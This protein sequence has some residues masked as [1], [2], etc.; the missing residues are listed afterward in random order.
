MPHERPAYHAYCSPPSATAPPSEGESFLSGGDPVVVR[1]R[2][3]NNE[4]TIGAVAES[5]PACVTHRL[6][7]CWSRG[8]PTMETYASASSLSG[9]E[10]VF[11]GASLPSRNSMRGGTQL[12][13]PAP[14]RREALEVKLK[15]TQRQAPKV[16]EVKREA[17][18]VKLKPR[19][20]S[21]H[22]ETEKF[23]P[24]PLEALEVQLVKVPSSVRHSSIVSELRK[25]ASS[26]VHYG[27]VKPSELKKMAAAHEE[28][29][30]NEFV[31]FVSEAH[32]LMKRALEQQ[33]QELMRIERHQREEEARMEAERQQREANIKG[34]KQ[35]LEE[36]LMKKQQK[37]Q[38][39][40]EAEEAARVAVEEA[41]AEAAVEEAAASR[42]QLEADRKQLREV[43][44]ELL[45]TEASYRAD[46][47]FVS[48]RYLTPLREVMAPPSHH[49]VFSN[50][51]VLLQLH[52]TLEEDLRAAEG[53][54]DDTGRGVAIA[55]AFMKLAPFFKM[56]SV[57]SASYA[58]VPKAL[59]KARVEDPKLEAF[60]RHAAAKPDEPPLL[61]NAEKIS[62]VASAAIAV[63]A[64]AALANM[65]GNNMR[66]PTTSS[67]DAASVIQRAWAS[68]RAAPK[69]ASVT[70]TA[71]VT[72]PLGAGSSSGSLPSPVPPPPPEPPPPEG[73]TPPP[74]VNP[75][76]ALPFEASLAKGRSFSFGEGALGLVLADYQGAVVVSEEPQPG[77]QGFDLGVEFMSVVVG[78]NGEA[79]LGLS[80]AAVVAKLKALPRPLSLQLQAYAEPRAPSPVRADDDASLAISDVTLKAM[81]SEHEHQSSRRSHERGGPSREGR[82][83]SAAAM[84][85]C[86]PSFVRT[87]Q[88]SLEALLFRPVQRMCLYPLLFKQARS[89]RMASDG[90]G[91]P[92]IASDCLHARSPLIAHALPRSQALASQLKVARHLEGESAAKEARLTAELQQVFATIQQTLGNVNDQV[93]TLEM[94]NHTLRVLTAEV[95]KGDE[96]V[97]PDRVLLYEC[98]VEME[99]TTASVGSQKKSSGCC[100]GGGGISSTRRTFKWYVFSDALLVCRDRAR[101]EL[102]LLDQVELRILKRTSQA[103]RESNRGSV[104]GRGGKEL[105][106]LVATRADGEEEEFTC[107]AESER[108]MQTLGDKFN[109]ARDA[110]EKSA[111]KS[112]R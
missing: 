79:V 15:T 22:G 28:G 3:V 52:T 46:L 23:E 38:A 93:R 75:D 1:A 18:E 17:L 58:D 87:Q 51:E 63:T 71:S 10:G 31:G 33:Q 104:F 83:Q 108:A 105:F 100:G 97:T 66:V 2:R 32:D 53:A 5:R 89:P 16:Q 55:A 42:R 111:K 45:A 35:L 109:T 112:R 102:L 50:L 43:F 107:Y 4:R 70:Q 56:Y 92:L 94:R 47:R 98:D 95:Y 81:A 61:P 24:P 67:E 101:V 68:K 30:A 8:A 82:P 99:Q 90:L 96:L 41:E 34:R 91:L 7:L 59:E 13:E 76:R 36:L 86:H 29:R 44:A 37:A 26:I 6:I 27:G 73:A 65:L 40:S 49:A 54:D 110:F 88:A 78:V 9:E 106:L 64:A 103:K 19:R 72:K 84:D 11:S 39:T 80:K 25:R 85:A 20:K 77:G 69:A 74:E 14:V 60:L 57:Y 62:N 12:P 21:R 48:R